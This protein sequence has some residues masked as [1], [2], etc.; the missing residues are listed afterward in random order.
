MPRLFPSSIIG[1]D[2]L[3]IIL[4]QTAPEKRES[5]MDAVFII[6]GLGLFAAFAAYAAL[7]KGL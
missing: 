5:R 3:R 7:L 2:P 6:L 4:L 1:G